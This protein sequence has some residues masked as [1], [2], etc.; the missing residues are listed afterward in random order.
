MITVTNAWTFEAGLQIGGE[1]DHLKAAFNLGDSYS[2]STP[3]STTE[4][5]TQPRP[6]DGL[7]SCGY[8]TFLPYYIQYAYE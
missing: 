7:I 5:L 3:E 8:W 2:Y 6:A 4:T 1:G